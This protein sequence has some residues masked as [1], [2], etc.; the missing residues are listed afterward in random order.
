MSGGYEILALKEEDVSKMLS[1]SVHLGSQNI[2]F[3]NKTYVYKRR[4][5]G[6]HII[7][8]RRT[9]EKLLLAAR[10]ITAIE[11][12]SEVFVI[13]GRPHGQRAVLKF[14]AHTGA[15][16]IAGRF[17]PG[18]F[19]NQ[20]QSAFREPRL[21]IVTDPAADH[22]AII[23]SSYVNIPVIAFCDTDTPLRYIDI[24][25]PCNTKGKFSI[26]LMWWFLTREVLRM[27]GSIPREAKWD[28]VVD[29][30]FYREPE[31]SEKEEQADTKAV[32][33][34][35]DIGS[36]PP[37]L[38]DS[39]ANDNWDVND[40]PLSTPV[41]NWGN[42]DVIPAVAP[43]ENWGNDTPVPTTESWA[44]DIPPPINPVNTAGADNPF[45]ARATDWAAEH[46]DWSS[47][48]APDLNSSS[49]GGGNQQNWG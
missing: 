28:V 2:N 48:P 22:Q 10:V 12:P 24:A 29:L 44:D 20:I 4:E 32:P 27:R 30:Y 43:V 49:W 39:A 6:V 38:M 34:L 37:V 47:S 13:S 9:W 8:L 26:G 45:A 18:T 21:L 7:N 16:A 19:T 42:D 36:Y 41:E 40:I 14:A 25:I 23:E 35:K 15:T 46:E 3:Q 31:E 33:T 11:H 5:D 17:T 1:A